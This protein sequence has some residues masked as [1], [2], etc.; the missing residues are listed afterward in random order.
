MHRHKSLM[1]CAIPNSFFK[2]NRN[3]L[4]HAT[5][6]SFTSLNPLFI[7]LNPFI[8]AILLHNYFWHLLLPPP[9][10]HHQLFSL[11]PP[12]LLLLGLRRIWGMKGSMSHV[13]RHT[14]H[15]TRHTSHVT[16]HRWSPYFI[17]M[18]GRKLMLHSP[19]L[20]LPAVVMTMGGR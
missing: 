17:S 20:P 19:P 7:T 1:L 14:S 12:P 10:L 16:R 2:H 15:V 8:S 4:H 5:I 13:T 11:H 6:K 18:E 3:T 9:P